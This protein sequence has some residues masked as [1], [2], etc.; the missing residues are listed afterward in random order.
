[1]SSFSNA[2]MKGVADILEWGQFKLE[3]NVTD[4]VPESKIQWEEFNDE[5]QEK[6]ETHKPSEE[7]DDDDDKI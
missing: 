1:M 7:Y 5:T 3:G 4:R 2:G 6:T